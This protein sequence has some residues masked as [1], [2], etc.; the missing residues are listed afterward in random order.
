MN[1]LFLIDSILFCSVGFLFF[2]NILLIGAD[3]FVNHWALPA[4]LGT[5]FLIVLIIAFVHTTGSVRM[6][7]LVL[8]HGVSFFSSALSFPVLFEVLSRSFIVGVI[9]LVSSARCLFSL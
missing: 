4:R 3:S 5:I 8:W 6:D 7:V 1:L 2:L 9:P